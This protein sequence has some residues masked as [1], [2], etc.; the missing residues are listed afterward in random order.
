MSVQARQEIVKRRE[1][2][3]RDTTT[4]EFLSTYMGIT[5]DEVLDK[6]LQIIMLDKGDVEFFLKTVAEVFYSQLSVRALR[7][8]GLGS[9]AAFKQALRGR[10]P[11]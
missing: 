2:K 8:D 5:S 1:K 4:A 3:L 6:L 11:A 7:E 9:P 10:L